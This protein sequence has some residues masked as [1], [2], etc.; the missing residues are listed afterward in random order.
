MDARR[1]AIHAHDLPGVIDSE[2]LSVSDAGER[3]VDLLEDRY[4]SRRGCDVATNASRVNISAHNLT[5]VIDPQ[6][7]RVGGA[8][9]GHI[10]RSEEIPGRL[11]LIL[12]VG[13]RVAAAILSEQSGAAGTSFTSSRN[14]FLKE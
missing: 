3:Y 10:D 4:D 2:R 7:V 14:P 8:V 12:R 6:G 13:I 1:I 5:V 9:E 11:P